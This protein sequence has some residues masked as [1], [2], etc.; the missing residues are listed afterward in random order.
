M[1]SNLLSLIFS[2]YINYLFFNL[3]FLIWK[4]VRN[5]IEVFIELYHEIF[6]KYSI[7]KRIRIYNNVCLILTLKRYFTDMYNLFN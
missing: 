5:F 1:T 7:Y 3:K 2:Q 4:I 6:I